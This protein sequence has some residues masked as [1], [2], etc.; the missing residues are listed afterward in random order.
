MQVVNTNQFAHI[1]A[2]VMAA[3]NAVGEAHATLESAYVVVSKAFAAEK[4]S[5]DDCRTLIAMSLAHHMSKYRGDL[6]ALAAFQKDK[7]ARAWYDTALYAKVKYDF[8]T[9]VLGA[10]PVKADSTATI[11][12]KASERAAYN[13]L[14]EACGGDAKRM[15]LVIKSLK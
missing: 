9:Y 4:I 5:A 1:P 6:K 13:A 15:S 3:I 8:R 12:I 11:R 14:F 7:A 2:A 10:K